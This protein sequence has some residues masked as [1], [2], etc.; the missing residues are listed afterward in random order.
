MCLWRDDAEFGS[1]QLEGLI[2]MARIIELSLENRM[3]LADVRNQLDGTL[4]VL[5]TLIDHRLPD[6]DRG[7]TRRASNAVAIGKAMGLN[8]RE[9][10][11]LRIAAT[12]AD[13]GLLGTELYVAGDSPAEDAHVLSD[14]K[15]P[16]LGAQVARSARFSTTVQEAIRAHHERLDGSGYPLGLRGSG[17][18]LAARILAV[19]DV[20]EHAAGDHPERL[21]GNGGVPAELLRGAGSTY[22]AEVVRALLRIL[23]ADDRLVS[24]PLAELA[25]TESPIALE[26]E[27][28]LAG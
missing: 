13:V 8:H 16:E 21:L 28:T 15:H 23:G 19:C 3:L 26:R 12:L 25:P 7:S 9:L 17:I 6:Y 10:S 27:A 1:D 14:P 24:A 11:D 20:H 4:D 2:L 18:P 22:D 5:S